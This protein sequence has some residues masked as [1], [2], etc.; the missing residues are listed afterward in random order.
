MEDADDLE[1]LVRKGIRRV[2]LEDD[3]HA[4][5]PQQAHS[6]V[7]TTVSH[8]VVSHASG[9]DSEPSHAPTGGAGCKR[10]HASVHSSVFAQPQHPKPTSSPLFASS[11]RS[12]AK[13]SPTGGRFFYFYFYL[14]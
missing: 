9:R 3:A 11:I 4:R 7:L 10:T 12:A 13:I 2:R 14:F 6:T 5:T 8:T 1:R